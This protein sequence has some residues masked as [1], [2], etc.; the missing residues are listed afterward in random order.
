[1]IRF[2]VKTTLQV[3]DNYDAKAEVV[4]DTEETFEQGEKVDAD[5]F[6]EDGDRVD[7]QFADGSMAYGVLKDE[8][9]VM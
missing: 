5:I 1:M 4:D 6:N 9:E 7:V 8:I 2:R 3:I